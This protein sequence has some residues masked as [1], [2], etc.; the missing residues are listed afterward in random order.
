M[1]NVQVDEAAQLAELEAKALTLRQKRAAADDKI[2]A[3]RIEYLESQ[4]RIGEAQL[5]RMVFRAV[6]QLE[7]WRAALRVLKPSADLPVDA[8][9]VAS[10]ADGSEAFVEAAVERKPV[11]D[12]QQ[13][14]A[15]L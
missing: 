3:A 4:I 7:D 5:N 14:P 8:G 6:K 11:S 10:S 13:E 1:V 12:G 9:L 2:K 15:L